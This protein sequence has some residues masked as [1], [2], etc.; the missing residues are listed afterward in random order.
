MFSCNMPEEYLVRLSIY[1]MMIYGTWTKLFPFMF[2]LYLNSDR[3][4]LTDSVEGV[5]FRMQLVLRS[6][7]YKRETRIAAKIENCMMISIE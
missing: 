5:K 3:R 7:G 4:V 2:H 6:P 1:S